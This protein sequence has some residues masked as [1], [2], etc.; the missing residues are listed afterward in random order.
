MDM[1]FA[2]KVAL[3][4]GGSKGIGAGIAKAFGEAGAHVA[5]GYARDRDA[6][7]RVAAE[8][9]AAGGRAVTVQCDLAQTA[10]IEAMVA[11]TVAAFGPIEILVN[12][13]GVFDYKP[14]SAITEAHFHEHFDVNVLGVL[15]AAKHAAAHFAADGGSIINISSLAARADAPGR[16]VYTATKAAVNAITMALALELADRKI[17]VNAIMPGYIDTE[18]A[19]AFGI[20]GTEAEAKLLAA[21]PLAKRPG[22]PS[23][24]SPVALFLA[25]AR[26]G[27]MT[28][29]ILSVGGGRR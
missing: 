21:T 22:L 27:W 29:E 15:M 24:I 10:D 1:E 13:A 4:T 25:S 8:I 3:V 6:A 16:V 19:R 17:R 7:E 18:G 5:V 12:S 20:R 14:L 23:D 26:S 11:R 28:G 9:E 2:G